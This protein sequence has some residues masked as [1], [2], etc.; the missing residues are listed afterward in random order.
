M[1]SSKPGVECRDRR[2]GRVFSRSL[3][4][5]TRPS[6]GSSAIV[7]PRL[8]LRPPIV[9][10]RTA[11]VTTSVWIARAASVIGPA[12]RGGVEARVEREQRGE[13]LGGV[14][15]RD[16]G[17]RPLGHRGDLAR[18]EDDVRVVRQDDDLARVD[19]VDRLEQLAGARVGRLAALD[20]GRDPEVA[21]DRGQAVAGD[22]RDDTESRRA[23]HGGGIGSQRRTGRRAAVG[24]FRP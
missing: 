1:I 21:E 15:R 16:D 17:H 23:R 2:R 8:T 18:G 19:A 4:A 5:A 10:S 13:A 7:W 24:A 9:A 14:A 3:S 12:L 11:S 20:D 6:S 22:D